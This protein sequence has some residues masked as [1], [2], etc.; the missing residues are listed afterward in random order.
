M[1]LS[2]SKL[3]R[4]RGKTCIYLLRVLFKKRSAKS[5]FDDDYVIFFSSDFQY[6]SIC[7][8]YP[9][10][11]H[12]QVDA[13]QMGTHNICLYYGCNL[14]TTEL[15][16]YAFIGVRAE[17]RSNTVLVLKFEPIYNPMCLKIAR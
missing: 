14:K 13:I 6:K 3:L 2:F 12:R 9:F 1:H 4:K 7:C 16:D 15:P 10:E 17:I 5:L 8:G 11:L